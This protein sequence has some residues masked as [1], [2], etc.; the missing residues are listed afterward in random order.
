MTDL[1]NAA[2]DA[3][4]DEAGLPI[5]ETICPDCKGGGGWRYYGKC[6]KCSGTGYAI[7]PFGQKIIDLMEHR[8]LV[9]GD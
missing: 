5:L 7:T 2:I 1:Q 6:L 9:W 8:A 3:I 4:L